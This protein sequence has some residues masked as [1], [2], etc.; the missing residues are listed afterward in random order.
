MIVLMQR[1]RAFPYL[2]RKLA[3]ANT[4]PEWIDQNR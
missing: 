4:A 3:D 2:R 1:L